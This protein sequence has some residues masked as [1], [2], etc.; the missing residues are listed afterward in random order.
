M[1]GGHKRKSKV[2]GKDNSRKAKRERYRENSPNPRFCP[3]IPRQPPRAPINK[4]ATGLTTPGSLVTRKYRTR[5]M[6]I[7]GMI[8]R[9]KLTKLRI[10]Q[11]IN[12]G[13]LPQC[14]IGILPLI[15]R[16]VVTGRTY[17]A[18]GVGG[19]FATRAL[20][21]SELEIPPVFGPE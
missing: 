14:I 20:S 10:A 4:A 16:G 8:D 17:R 18:L 21:Q 11:I 5:L 9:R 15:P 7:G 1:K 2:G 12:E 19:C 6:R 3:D 13:A